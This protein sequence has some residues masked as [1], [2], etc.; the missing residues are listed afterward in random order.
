M[1]PKTSEPVVDLSEPMPK[2]YSFLRKGNV[3]LTAKCRKLTNE[4]G[5]PVV[6]VV[7]GKEQL[8]IRIP[9]SILHQVREAER[10]S[11]ESRADAV[12]KKDGAVAHEFETALLKHFPATPSD[13]VQRIVSHA[14]V[15]KKKRVA[16]TGTLSLEDK[17]RLA[18]R[19]HVR[20][21]HTDYDR[22][23]KDG[24]AR[25]EARKEVLKK[26]LEVLKAWT[27]K[28]R[29]GKARTAKTGIVRRS[30]TGRLVRRASLDAAGKTK[31]ILQKGSPRRPAVHK[32]KT[33]RQP[34]QAEQ[35][36]EDDDE[37][38]VWGLDVD[39]ES[40]SDWTP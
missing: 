35:E 14:L 6:V 1:A 12:K 26:T 37:S 25:D 11:R 7:R 9:S 38:D 31:A 10:A 16:R 40:D 19:A 30:V 36:A 18:V 28:A 39:M 34:K 21:C 33:K 27:G 23:L 17:V 22:L 4:A 20:H 8:G 32:G 3:Y 5:K 24:V 13:L 2:G 29:T 15:K